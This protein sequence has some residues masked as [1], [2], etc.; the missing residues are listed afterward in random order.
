MSKNYQM[1][2]PADELASADKAGLD[3]LIATNPEAYQEGT[4]IKIGVGIDAAGDP[5]AANDAAI[6]IVLSSKVVGIILTPLT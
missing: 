3:A 2:I 1:L 4:Q 5:V 6:F